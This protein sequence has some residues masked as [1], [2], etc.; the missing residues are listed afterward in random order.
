MQV[1]EHDKSPG[2]LS[3]STVEDLASSS[4]LPLPRPKVRS[5][6]NKIRIPEVQ[7]LVA[8]LRNSKALSEQLVVCWV[9]SQ[10]VNYL[11]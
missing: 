3:G 5:P 4:K 7:S 6:A 2:A 10:L 9:N 8:G 11:R 1:H